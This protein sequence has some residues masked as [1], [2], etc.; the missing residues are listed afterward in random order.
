VPRRTRARRI[1]NLAAS[2]PGLNAALAQARGS[3][4]VR[5]DIHTQFAPDYIAECL[6]ALE[7]T[8]AD[9]VGGP[10]VARG[11]GTRP[12]RLP[13]SAAGWWVA[14]SRDRAYEGE[15][16]TIYLGCWPRAVFERFGGFDEQLVRNQDDEHNLRLRQARACGKA[17]ASIRSISRAPVSGSQAAS[18]CSTATGGPSFS[19]ST[20]ASLRQLVPAL[21]VAALAG[22]AGGALVAWAAGAAAG[23]LRAVPG[24]RRAGGGAAGGRR[25]SAGAPAGRDRHL[26]SGLWRGYLA[27]HARRLAAAP[28]PEQ[29][30]RLTR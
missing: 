21:F 13:F 5:F 29:W 17:R 6:A 28:Q 20:P 18:S 14:R 26:S 24:G 11:Q 1:D 9:N 27:R 4:I 8:G 2:S 23:Q 15:A 16:D 30:S 3:V 25:V 12:S 22:A 7:R 10:W 19:P